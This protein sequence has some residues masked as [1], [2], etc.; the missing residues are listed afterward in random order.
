MTRFE[1]IAP[2]T[3]RMERLLDAPVETVWRWL[4]EP[5]LR[6]RWFAGGT[7]P[8]EGAELELVFDHDHLSD[9]PV[10]YPESH[11]KWQG[12]KACERVAE[13][14]P[15]RRLAFTWDGGVEGIVRFDLSDADGRTRLVLTHGGIS[16]APAMAG[17]GGGWM[18]HLEVLEARIAGRKVADFWA[19][20]RQAGKEVAAALA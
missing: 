10:P 8:S 17:F 4:V 15:P 7:A 14:D 6:R 2:D 13:F 1:R 18:S 16:G 5:E 11:A 20:H 19:L 9:E 12:A 3:L